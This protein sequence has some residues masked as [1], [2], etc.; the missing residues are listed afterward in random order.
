MPSLYEYLNGP[1]KAV[2]PQQD[3]LVKNLNSYV[4]NKQILEAM[5]KEDPSNPAMGLLDAILKP[6]S[7]PGNLVRSGIAEATGLAKDIPQLS[8]VSGMQE[9]KDILS[10][11]IQVG[12]GDIP[13]LRT[14]KG[15]SNL[16]RLP[17]M[18]GAFTGD[19]LTDPLSYIGAPTSFSRK[20]AAQILV[21]HTIAPKSKVL[22]DIIAKSTRGSSLIDELAA[23]TPQKRMA[24]LQKEVNVA[25]TK[26]TPIDVADRVGKVALAKEQLANYLA[27]GL[28][29][30]GHAG[31]M[32]RLEVLTGSRKAAEEVYK[33]LPEAVKGGVIMTTPLGTPW[34]NPD[35]SYKRLTSGMGVYPGAE[36]VNKTKAIIQELPPMSIVRKMLSGKAGDIYADAT[37]GIAIENNPKLADVLQVNPKVIENPV[38]EFAT[39]TERARF[40]DFVNAKEASA[41]RTVYYQELQGRAKA[42]AAEA[43]L[44]AKKWADKSID[45]GNEYTQAA[46]DAFFSPW[47][48]PAST[49]TDAQI[50]GYENGIKMRN[51]MES[52]FDEARAMGIDIGQ[53]GT[54]KTYSPLMYSDEYIEELMKTEKGRLGQTSW[55]PTPGRD[56][57]I[58]TIMDPAVAKEHGYLIDPTNETLVALDSRAVNRAV[59]E[60]R[61]ETDPLKV[62]QKYSTLLANRISTKKFLDRLADTGIGF[63]DM[64][65]LDAA[66]TK[67]NSAVLIGIAAK[68]SPDAI[69]FA[70][71]ELAK[72]RKEVH[73][74]VKPETLRQLQDRV[75]LTRQAIKN[76]YDNRVEQEQSALRALDTAQAEVNKLY[77]DAVMTDSNLKILARQV[78]DNE[79]TIAIKQRVANALRSK[80][81]RTSKKPDLQMVNE[82]LTDMSNAATPEEA[83]FFQDIMTQLD[84]DPT[85]IVNELKKLH[86]GQDIAVEELGN[87]RFVQKSLIKAEQVN[88]RTT[89]DNYV[90]A[91]DKRNRLLAEKQ[92]ATKLKNDAK[93]QYAN[94]ANDLK[95]E[96]LTT[97]RTLMRGYRDAMEV[98]SEYTLKHKQTLAEMKRAGASDAEMLAEKN[99][100][101][102][103]A[104]G[105]KNEVRIHREVFKDSIS[106]AEKRY[107]KFVGEYANTLLQATKG[108]SKAE[109]EVLQA[110]TTEENIRKY[111]DIMATNSRDSQET[112][113]A[114]GDLKK[115]FD[116]VR[117]KIPDKVFA[118]LAESE[119]ALLQNYDAFTVS[120]DLRKKMVASD[121]G[122]AMAKQ[123]IAV[124]AVTP[125]TSNF[126][127]NT[128]ITKWL[129]DIYHTER[130]PSSFKKFIEDTFDPLQAIW[131]QTI[132]TGRGPGFVA[133][134]LIGGMFMNYQGGV[135]IKDMAQSFDAVVKMRNVLAEVNAMFPGNA[136]VTNREL[137][138]KEFEKRMADVKIG[139]SNIGQLFKEFI[140]RG[141]FNDTET[142]FTMRQL[143]KGG[144]STEEKYYNQ[145]T[146]FAENYHNPAENKYVQGYRDY[147]DFLTSNKLQT[148]LNDMN[149]TT[150]IYMRFG[151]FLSGYKEYGNF[152]SAMDKVSLLHFNYSDLSKAED[153]IRRIVP[154]YTWIR[155]NIPAQLRSIALQPGKIQR[156]MYANDSFREYYGSD[157]SWVNQV[158]PEYMTNSGG[159]FSRFTFGNNNQLGF[160]SKMP[161]EDINKMF[162]VND[163]FQVSPRPQEV[164]KTLGPVGIP[165]QVMSGTDYSTGQSINQDAQVAGYYRPLGLL[166]YM[167]TS[168]DETGA[169]TMGGT[170]NLFLRNA[171][172]IL[173]IGERAVSGVNALL[174]GNLPFKD[175]FLSKNQQNTGVSG[176][177]NTTGI[178]N[179]VG[180]GTTT[181]TD[182][183]KSG[184]L[185]GKSQEQQKAISKA[186]NDLGI[187]VQWIRDL[188]AQG[189]L[190]S[191]IAMLIEAGKQQDKVAPTKS[192]LSDAQRKKALNAINIL[193]SP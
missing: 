160:F 110:V 54:K 109:Y 190:P 79:Q 20:S 153:G 147:I 96:G 99:T 156:A 58:A 120:G 128:S 116:S 82:I 46:E 105:M 162:K 36:A 9:L 88:S 151:A 101:K 75:R 103:Y 68:T 122:E 98:L 133:T 182:K 77:K 38:N 131:K 192:T 21:N 51:H 107:G 158:L 43:T 173:G 55:D 155:N 3:A 73:A 154:F 111:I 56:S 112:L 4:T 174:G 157:D 25:V 31:I 16:A 34:K 85:S 175:F 171:V 136:M 74:L 83:K 57:H 187:D 132:T 125:S 13:A 49:A 161:Y 135:G 61:Y 117:S 14:V 11:K 137:A 144:F 130:N 80:I 179:L 44:A 66:V 92:K 65:T 52:L 100:Y 108:L 28:H 15:E 159:F 76:H 1:K 7:V 183:S 27:E 45:N 106:A 139:D 23:A 193:N 5:G 39:R 95:L 145:S 6:L 141:G 93:R 32:K 81:Y 53:I 64:P 86:I 124:T 71:K 181:S 67:L 84:A 62:F 91:L 87:A 33:T 163:K 115:A 167:S 134:N 123:G 164:L 60:N 30:E 24:E 165:F 121:L 8:N 118:K 94:V 97:V 152:R 180:L 191:E 142:N 138:A 113:D 172:P 59:G 177:L 176:L 48:Q 18:L 63:N 185:Y 150:E 35:G 42:V 129:E 19:V 29:G 186:A 69:N 149:Q 168:T 17:K 10:G 22:D 188:L 143:E 140:A 184:V 78:T 169:T 70:K 47:K 102:T 178:T 119:K 12:T 2:D 90:A 126:F 127:A 148:F 146:K 170:A 41:K 37:R 104:D 40:I 166:P 50:A 114:M 26:G 189:Y 89:I 72:A